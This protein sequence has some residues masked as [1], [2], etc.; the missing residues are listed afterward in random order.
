[1]QSY[2]VSRRTRFSPGAYLAIF[3]LI[4]VLL[5]LPILA[6]LPAPAGSSLGS[7]PLVSSALGQLP[8]AFIPRGQNRQTAQFEVYGAGNKLTFTP[9]DITLDLPASAQ[10]LRLSFVN[11]TQAPA[12]VAG[13]RLPTRINDYRGQEVRNWQTDVPAY[14]GITYQELY[15]G[16]ALHYEGQDG[17]LKSTFSLAPGADPAQIRWLYAGASTLAVDQ[18]SGDLLVTLP[19]HTEVIERAPI[20]WQEINGQRLPVQV[21]YALAADNSI[22]FSLGSYNSSAPLIIDPTIVYDT[23][24]NLG[25]FDSGL[26]IT[27]D[28]AGNAYIIGRVYDTN[29]DVLIAKLSP[30]GGLAFATYLRGSAGDFGDGIALDASGDIYVAGATDSA[31]FPI[32][33]AAQPVKNGV[34]RDAFIAKLSGADGALLFSTFF[35]GSR[36]DEIHDITLN[37]AG[38]IYVVG[39]TES[40]DFPTVN[41]IQSGLNLNQCFCEDTFVT[42]LSPDAM[43]VLYST[44]LG[45]SFE[46]YGESIALDGGDNIYITGR[47]QSDDY[48]TLAAIQPNR[49]GVYQDED[50][51]I[52]KI[53]ASGSLVY[54]TYLGGTDLDTVRRL[55]VDTA[56][57]AY[58]AGST[59]S[60]DFPTTAGAYQENYIGGASACG[61][62]GFG[63]PVNCYDVFVTKIVPDGSSLAY[64][65]YLGGGLDDYATGIAL[66]ES[67]EV[68]FAG[69]TNSTDFPGVTRTGPGADITVAKMNASGSDLLYTVIISSAV[70]N[71]SNGITLSQ[72]GDIYITAGQNAPSDLYVA[73][74]SESGAPPPPPPTPTFTPAPPTP[75]PAP[76]SSLHVGDLDGN[77]TWVFRNRY[78]QASVTITVHDANHNPLS[79]TTVSGAWSSGYSGSAQCTTDSTGR[80]TISTGAILRKTAHATFTVNGV[81]YASFTYTP[82]GNHDPDND[83]N[84]TRIVVSRP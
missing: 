68:Y 37:D 75:T 4:A 1:M 23:T 77:S 70:A 16:I 33:N 73:R 27:T 24:L 49:A 28:S 63:G 74:I 45:G 69:Y 31:D 48:P 39:Y 78:W 21:A 9:Q 44:Y 14:A 43:T 6:S 11:A 66:N 72:N 58:L 52:S 61:T 40:T 26:D 84:G 19:D 38:E 3:G 35:G 54:S 34:T 83:S 18:A 25:Y 13:E 62:P 5:I 56:G 46:D 22:S 36:S 50:L 81:A 59:R 53:S 15:P 79:G 30:N 67:G 32:L 65:T 7:T 71:G 2:P 76:T 60:I 80:C 17:S 47:T 20:A 41:P 42:R 82:A 10:P 29:N 64:S 51:F 12:L 55:A 8:L 57:N